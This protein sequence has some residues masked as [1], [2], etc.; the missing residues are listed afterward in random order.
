MELQEELSE[1]QRNKKA[2]PED[3]Q[4]RAEEQQRFD[5]L[6]KELKE[7]LAQR[8]L[9]DKMFFRYEMNDILA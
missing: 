5:S 6:L 2:K 4:N 9:E 8:V 3:K 7:L 1:L